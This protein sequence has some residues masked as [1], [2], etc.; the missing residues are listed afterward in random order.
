MTAGG[1]LV[2]FSRH[3]HA[4]L[5]LVR[6]VLQ[7]RGAGAFGTARGW[8]TRVGALRLTVLTSSLSESSLA[9]VI[10]YLYM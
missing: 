10:A 3:R 8:V 6:A 4:R 7:T 2:I 1:T 9:I 5:R